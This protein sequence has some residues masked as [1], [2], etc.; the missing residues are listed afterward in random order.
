MDVATLADLVHEAGGCRTPRTTGGPGVPP[1]CV[2]G[3]RKARL[4]R[5][6]KP[7]AHTW[8]MSYM[9]FPDNFASLAVLSEPSFTL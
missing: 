5:H 2:R 9:Y 7:P 4:G 3:S 6:L 8:R 1:I